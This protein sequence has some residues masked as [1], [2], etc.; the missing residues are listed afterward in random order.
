MRRIGTD[1]QLSIG[2]GTGERGFSIETG[3]VR[4]TTKEKKLTKKT[5][6]TLVV[7]PEGQ[8]RQIQLVKNIVARLEKKML[9][10]TVS[11]ADKKQMQKELLVQKRLLNRLVAEKESISVPEQGSKI[12]REEIP[13]I[14]FP[15]TV[16]RVEEYIPPRPLISE[17]QEQRMHHHLRANEEKRKQWGDEIAKDIGAFFLNDGTPVEL[18][19]IKNMWLRAKSRVTGAFGEAQ[20]K[21][22]RFVQDE[23]RLSGRLKNSVIVPD[24]SDI[25]KTDV[26]KT[27]VRPK[28]IFK[29][30]VVAPRLN[31]RRAV[32]LEKESHLFEGLPRV[33][34][35][36]PGKITPDSF[37]DSSDAIPFEGEGSYAEAAT[38]ADLID[39]F[40]HLQYEINSRQEFLRDHI[41][42]NQTAAAQK[43]E[44]MSKEIRQL[45]EEQHILGLDQP[46]TKKIIQNIETA[47]Q[48]IMNAG[49]RFP[50]LSVEKKIEQLQELRQ[51][52]QGFG[53]IAPLVGYVTREELVRALPT[54]SQEQKKI[55]FQIVKQAHHDLLQQW[56]VRQDH[57]N[58]RNRP[59]MENALNRRLET[60]IDLLAQE[61]I[62]EENADTQAAA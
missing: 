60:L 43:K 11:A 49:Q 21:W 50:R 19:G 5:A 56:R 12:Q 48:Y 36:E 57:L 38:H 31:S 55:F 10:D 47:E 9:Q 51:D 62:P 24:E 37:E 13:V 45:Q 58:I 29:K 35:A 42:E 54:L 27:I 22:L 17:R 26:G 32:S 4:K 14:A 16:K 53:S 33:E 52:I 34:H 39:R 61:I 2:A 59:V 3:P 18:P 30:E 15:D 8:T 46:M 7:T 23:T 20:K 1:P 44:R 6:D 28:A 40:T 41:A 25:E